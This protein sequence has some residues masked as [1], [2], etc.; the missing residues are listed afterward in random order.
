MFFMLITVELNMKIRA[1]ILIWWQYRIFMNFCRHEENMRN[2]EKPNLWNETSART[3]FEGSSQQVCVIEICCLNSYETASG[4]P[5]SSIIDL[6]RQDVPQG[7][8]LIYVFP[9][10]RA[11]GLS[12]EVQGLFRKEALLQH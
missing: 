1:I 4:G 12:E 9:I 11:E 5:Q 2:V 10:M 6:Y 8:P 3:C 7:H